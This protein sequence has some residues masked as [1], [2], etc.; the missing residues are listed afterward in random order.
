MPNSNPQAV[1]FANN[2]ARRVADDMVSCYLTMKRLAQVWTGQSVAAVIPNDATL[3]ADGS[4]TD[5]RPQITDAM[6]N[7]LIANANTLIA[8]F[9]ANTNLILNQCLQ[10]SVNADSV[11]Q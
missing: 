5:G 3:I 9:E 8:S 2:Y 7:V 10:V 1:S 4:A 11:V 6:V